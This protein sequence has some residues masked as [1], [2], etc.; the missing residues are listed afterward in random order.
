MRN[1]NE[2]IER[3]VNGIGVGVGVDNAF[4]SWH[5]RSTVIVSLFISSWDDTND[6]DDDTHQGELVVVRASWWC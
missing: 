5:Q 2:R 6:D 3:G 1:E 4:A